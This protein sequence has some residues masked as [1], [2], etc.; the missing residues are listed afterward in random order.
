MDETIKALLEQLKLQQEQIKLQQEQSAEQLRLQREEAAEKELQHRKE[1]ADM[2]A[3]LKEVRAAPPTVNIQPAPPDQNA[4][5]VEKVQ[6]LAMSMRKSN[7]VK[8]F[9]ASGESD[10]QKFLKR[11]TEELVTLKQMVVINDDLSKQEYVPI[12]R[13]S[14]EFSVIER[15]DQVFK[16][17]PINPKAWDTIDIVD[18]HKLMKEEFGPKHNDVANVLKQ[19][20]PSRLIKSADKK[21]QDIYYE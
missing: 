6:R 20:G 13:A 8:L 21:V 10:V 15:I 19:F 3:S 1:M 16:K 7:R 12:F 17:D 9:K 5:R 11:F 2:I 4:V 14:L 18:L